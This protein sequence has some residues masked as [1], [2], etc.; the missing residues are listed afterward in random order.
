[1]GYFSEEYPAEEYEHDPYD[2]LNAYQSEQPHYAYEENYDWQDND[3]GEEMDEGTLLSMLADQGLDMN[4]EEAMEYAADIIQ[5][6]QEAYFARERAKEKGIKGFHNKGKGK[7]S[8]S[9]GR[10]FD[11]SGQLTLQERQQKI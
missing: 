9:S 1:M 5:A 8:G 7:S 11:V 10:A 2:D 4:D 6:E 3:L